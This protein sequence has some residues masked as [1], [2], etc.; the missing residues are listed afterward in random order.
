[1]SDHN[2]L[3]D[4][5][6]AVQIALDAGAKD[7]WASISR[8]RS[9]DHGFHA[10]KLEKVQESTSR[11]LGISIYVDGRY[12]SHS[13]TDLRPERLAAFIR[14]A[15]A[16]TRAL[17]PDPYRLIPD[18]AL[19]AGRPTVDLDRVDPSLAGLTGDQRIEWC[20]EL[21]RAAHA[22]KRVIAVESGV[23]TGEG[24]GASASS[25]GFRGAWESTHIGWSAAVTVREDEDKRPEGSYY[26]VG[27]Y[28]AGLP[29]PAAVAEEALARALAR[30]GARKGPSARMTMVVDAQAAVSLLS[31]LLG[32]ANAASI[33]QGRSFYAGKLGQPLVSER[34]TILDDPLIPRGLASRHFDGE[35]ISAKPMPVIRAGVVENIYVDTYYGRK[36]G[37]TPTSGSP[38]NRVVTPGAQSLAELLREAGSGVYVTSWLGGNADPTTGDFSL[39]LRGHL[40]E[41]GQIGAPVGE[42]NVT[43]NLA[44]L[45]RGL[46]RLGNDPYPYSSLRA[47]SLV[48]EGVNF[49]GA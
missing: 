11:G 29:A 38:S 18:P 49:S 42:M 47:P 15:V 30:L 28:R 37:M 17:Q 35:G 7:A 9:V 4:A 14:D 21:D 39:G 24:E 8:D 45:F 44:E 1:M 10:G 3:K 31:R 12:S 41:N 23:F 19:F 27:R 33:Q 16:L 36:I 34:L 6:S 13:T 46:A 25:N 5:E 2:L 20:A 43:G 26:V 32:P 40:I 48:F 22:D